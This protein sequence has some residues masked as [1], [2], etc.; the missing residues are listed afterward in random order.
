MSRNIDCDN[1]LVIPKISFPCENYSIKVIGRK[2]PDYSRWVIEHVQNMVIDLDLSSIQ[3]MDSRNGNFQ[4]V[5]LF[6]N[7]KNI[8]QLKILHTN[9]L[10]NNRVKLVI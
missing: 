1:N 3:V 9:L 10:N 6:I 2:S 8:K 7:V 4:S 5:R